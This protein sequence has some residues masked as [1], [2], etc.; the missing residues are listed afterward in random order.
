MNFKVK[1]AHL[2]DNGDK[3]E[4]EAWV[5][6]ASHDEAYNAA[7][8]RFGRAVAQLASAT[9]IE[10]DKSKIEMGAEKH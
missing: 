5:E 3:V 10:I 8:A 2:L 1:L 6:A 7:R 4:M 9:E